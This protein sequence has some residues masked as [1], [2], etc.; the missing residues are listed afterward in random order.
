MITLFHVKLN[1]GN[2][3]WYYEVG[4]T[5]VKEAYS[6]AVGML[7]DRLQK[8]KVI[9]R[10]I[11]PSWADEPRGLTGQYIDRIASNPIASL[12]GDDFIRGDVWVAK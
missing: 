4:T 5:G 7:F 12:L 9:P 10:I 8:T 6:D 2:H 1:V 3:N 11:K